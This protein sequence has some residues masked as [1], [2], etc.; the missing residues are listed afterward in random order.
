[1][2]A[3]MRCDAGHDAV[4]M[5]PSR[6]TWKELSRMTATVS[7]RVSS[8]R[9]THLSVT[10]SGLPAKERFGFWRDLNQ[11][12]FEMSPIGERSPALDASVDIWQA[13]EL[14]F[15]DMR[16]LP[17]E[18]HKHMIS[19]ERTDAEILVVR[20]FRKGGQ[21]GLLQGEPIRLGTDE[22]H[23]YPFS[24]EFQFVSGDLEQVSAY[25]PYD[26]ID[27]DPSK[28]TAHRVFSA[29]DPVGR[30]VKS[31]LHSTIG[32]LKACDMPA[33]QEAA[34]A[35]ADVVRTSIHEEKRRSET[36]AMFER[37]RSHAFRSFIR[38]N[39]CNPG[40]DCKMVCEAFAASRATIYREF[41]EDGG[42]ARYIFSQRLHRA[43]LRLAATPIA[44]GDIGRVALESGFTEAS[45]FSKAFRKTYGASVMD[46]LY[47]N[48][49]RTAAVSHSRALTATGPGSAPF[50]L[51]EVFARN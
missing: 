42:I 7:D 31:A 20:Y 1:M 51:C 34:S 4:W 43:M 41:A 19:M 13:G 29:E 8:A 26:A 24:N 21:R 37:A 14:S 46:F 36:R 40:L 23:I 48:N 6:R 11:P 28:T 15:A 5:R 22:V 27:F 49:V 30:I 45:H 35:F 10:T 50:R 47:N 33:S 25:V 9:P 12:G 16:Y 39:I 18:R 2:F 44:K 3:T 38:E 32:S 17:G